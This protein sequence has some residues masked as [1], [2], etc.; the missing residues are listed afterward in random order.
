MY[1]TV[2]LLFGSNVELHFH[3]TIEPPS[4]NFQKWNWPSFIMERI[5]LVNKELHH[6]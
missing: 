5:C 4:W 1:S 6:N 2:H 3:L